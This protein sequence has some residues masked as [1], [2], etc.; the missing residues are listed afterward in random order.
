MVLS[1]LPNEQTL[2]ANTNIDATTSQVEDQ[3]NSHDL[4]LNPQKSSPEAENI[5]STPQKIS[6]EIEKIV[7]TPEKRYSEAEKIHSTPEK[8]YSECHNAKL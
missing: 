2:D 1:S 3:V 4:I 6:L 5:D 8:R 7:S